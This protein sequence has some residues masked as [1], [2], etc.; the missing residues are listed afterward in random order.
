MSV[1]EWPE[2]MEKRERLERQGKTVVF[3]NGCFD[4]LHRGHL[5]LLTRA[6]MQ[7]DHLVVGVNSDRSV[8]RLKG[9]QRPVLPLEDRM[10]LLDALNCVDDVTSFGE[11]TP[12]RL[13]ERLRPD[14]LVKGSDYA[15]DEIVGADV[16]QEHGGRVHR[17]ELLE[18][19]GTTE[20]L[21]SIREDSPH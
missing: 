18:G 1:L 5:H 15:P 2:L 14:V 9:D 4:L 8:R 19:K 3:T 7:G 20:I 6:R 16:V 12:L 10:A 21:R 13:I 17:V 11:D